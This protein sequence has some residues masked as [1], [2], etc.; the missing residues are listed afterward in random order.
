MTWPSAAALHGLRDLQLGKRAR[1]PRHVA[2]LVDEMAAAHLA[3]LVD[4]VGELEAAIFDV[5]GRLRVRHVAAVDVDD[6]AQR[7]P[8]RR[9]IN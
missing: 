3:H 8:R 1:Q 9:W 6:A 7:G 2:R 4:G 5:H